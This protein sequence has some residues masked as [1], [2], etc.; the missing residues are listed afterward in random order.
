M[1]NTQETTDQGMRHST[2]I[3]VTIA[4][5]VFLY[6][7]SPF[8]QV[9][10]GWFV[11]FDDNISH[12]VHEVSFGALFA[13][14]FVGVLVQLRTSTR[15]FA[16][17]IQAAIAAVILSIVT[18]ISTGLEVLTLPYLVPLAAIIWLH[19]DRTKFFSFKLQPHRGMVILMTL[20]SFSLLWGFGK[21]LS[22]AINEVRQHQ[23]HWGGMAAFALTLFV[24][25]YLAALRIHGWPLLAWTAGASVIVF[26][27]LSLFFR[28]DAS[29]RPDITAVFSIIWGLLFIRAARRSR[30]VPAVART[31]DPSDP[32][33]SPGPPGQDQPS[34]LR[35]TWRRAVVIAAIVAVVLAFAGGDSGSEGPPFGIIAIVLVMSLLFTTLRSKGILRRNRA[36]DSKRPADEETDGLPEDRSSRYRR[37]VVNAA[38]L[39]ALFMV[40]VFGAREAIHPPIPHTIESLQASSCMACHGTGDQH[41]PTIDWRTHN[42]YDDDAPRSRFPHCTG[43][44]DWSRDA[45]VSAEGTGLGDEWSSGPSVLASPAHSGIEGSLTRELAALVRGIDERRATP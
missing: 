16:G 32:R 7:F 12:R 10:L 6:L 1:S 3:G 15:N 5:L 19:P 24:I 33:D 35:R 21:E 18:A 44:H 45:V 9:F 30:P 43:C 39:V 34:T 41:A 22:K 27:V 2:F 4:F 28:F 26:G 40:G 8:T 37:Y 29:A 17:L 11:V 36:V 42:L 14:I 23:S 13:I 20:V 31:G 38:G 25:G